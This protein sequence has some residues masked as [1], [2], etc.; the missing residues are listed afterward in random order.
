MS[1]IFRRELQ[2]Y[3][4]S[5]IAY[6]F[7][8]VFNFFA[9]YFYVSTCITYRTTD[10][11]GLYGNMFMI[12]IF[13]VPILTMKLFSEERRQKTDQ[14]LL[15]SPVSLGGIVMGKFLAAMVVFLVAMASFL[16][17]TVILA[18]FTAV[19]WPVMLGNL[20]GMILLGG[21]FLSVGMFASSLTENQV[22]A[23]IG[24]FL[25]SM[26]LY[27]IDMVVPMVTGET[28]KSILTSLSFYTRYLEFTSG[29][30][31]FTTVLFFLSVMAIFIWLTIRTLEKR[32]WS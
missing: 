29:I 30:F 10:V 31:N 1:A 24:G 8:A 6:V 16:L 2:A 12:V 4:I 27:M 18:A 19:Q 23:A 28:L 20:F 17:F 32:R 13:I 14:I 3:F 5:P 25:G 22:I 9:A 26:V 11:S 21:V 7:L 15:T